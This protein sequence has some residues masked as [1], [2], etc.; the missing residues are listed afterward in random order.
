MILAKIR[1]KGNENFKFQILKQIKIL[2]FF[3]FEKFQNSSIQIF[4]L[5]SNLK[6]E[7]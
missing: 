1:G 3:N 7:I 5:V 2:Q 4:N 6:F